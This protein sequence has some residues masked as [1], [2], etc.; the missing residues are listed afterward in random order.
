M[1][2]DKYGKLNHLKMW[3]EAWDVMGKLMV[4]STLDSGDIFMEISDAGNNLRRGRFF[5]IVLKMEMHNLEMLSNLLDI[6]F[7]SHLLVRVGF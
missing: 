3:K 6:P 7:P 1:R 4:L 5:F 2:V